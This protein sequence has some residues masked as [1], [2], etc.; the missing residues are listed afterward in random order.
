MNVILIDDEP[1][2]HLIVKKMLAGMEGV[3]L[4]EAF[5]DTASAYAYLQQHEVDLILLDISLPKEN[6]LKFAARLRAENRLMPIVFMTS[7]KEHALE[8]F[9]VY[10]FD[11]LVKPIVR[12]RLQRTIRLVE[13][14]S[15]RAAALPFSAPDP[16]T[17][18]SSALRIRVL[19]G[20][21]LRGSGDIRAKWRSRK[22][23]ELFVYLLM[24]R[25]RFCS[26]SRL[27][28]DVFGGMP[29][30]NAEIYLNTT[31][32]QLRK[33]LEAVGRKQMLRSDSQHYALEFAPGDD[34][35]LYRFEDG[36]RE[37]LLLSGPVDLRRAL[38]LEELYA[39]SLFGER[40]FTWA[41]AYRE[42][43]IQLYASLSRRL[44]EEL[45][46]RGQAGEAIRLFTRLIA[47]NDLDEAPRLLLLEAL[48]MHN[49]RPGLMRQYA[50][51]VETLHRELGIE[52]S[53]ELTER[54]RNL[55]N[56]MK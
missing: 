43:C 20:I 44:G 47:Q 7:H 55:L 26:R 23:A 39:G 3:G 15:V 19:G 53:P 12:E 36:C 10:A 31:A 25:G 21:E 27:I 50:E 5:S 49:D 14:S 4:L 37:L 45:L 41:V 40:D 38:E 32:Y 11:Y 33:L 34:I 52:P 42:Q 46:H 16:I 13:Q 48:A 56:G 6:G 22:S 8:A 24:H 54:Y 18:S 17:E 35:D 1:A 2:M 28:E 51:Y 9:D 29:Q 30:K